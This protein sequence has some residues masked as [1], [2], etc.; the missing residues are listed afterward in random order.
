ML[1]EQGT[2]LRQVTFAL[3]ARGMPSGVTPAKV[4]P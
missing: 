4:E 1:F 3:G 2:W